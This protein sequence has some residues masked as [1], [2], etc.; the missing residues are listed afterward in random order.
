MA[1]STSIIV[2]S[3]VEGCH[4]PLATNT[5]PSIKR[6]RW[7]NVVGT[8]LPT[9]GAHKWNVQFDFD[10]K[11]KEVYSKSLVNVPESSGISMDEQTDANLMEVSHHCC[12]SF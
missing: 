9:V 4:G 12:R 10:G 8:V 2:G 3:R 1:H 11:S 7:V 5:N 6:R